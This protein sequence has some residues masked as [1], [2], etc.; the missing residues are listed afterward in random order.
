M[1][2]VC[3]PRS[4]ALRTAFGADRDLIRTVPSRGYQF[5]GEIRAAS[6]GPDLPTVAATI[7]PRSLIRLVPPTNLPEPVSELIG[8]E[9]ELAKCWASSARH[10]LV[11]LDWARAASARR[12]SASRLRVTCCRDLS[13]GSGSSS[14]RRCLIPSS[15][16]SP[17]PPRLG[18]SSLRDTASPLSVASAL[19]SKQLMLVL[20]NCEHVRR[21]SGANGRGVVAR[22]PRGARHRH[23]P[24][25]TPGRWRVGQPVP[26]L[27][28][29]AEGSPLA[30]THC[31]TAPSGCSSSGHAPPR[32]HFSPDAR[33]AGTMAGICRRLDGIPLAIE[34]A[35]ARVAAL[36]INGLA[37]RLDDRFGPA[38]GRPSHRNAAPSDPARDA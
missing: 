5:T 31:A 27:A 21:R 22:R 10:R 6:T 23:Q 9:N 34:L 30:T 29:P 32:R 8:R 38:H 36:G 17:S 13:M 18:S 26:P 25:A 19:R 28:V 35:A 20:D 7:R 2:T 24:R 14:W 11:T 12:A 1:R 4:P 16:Q 37:A 15:S 3:K 33:L